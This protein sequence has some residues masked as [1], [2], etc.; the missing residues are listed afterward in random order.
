M[1]VCGTGLLFEMN[2]KIEK[3]EV[4]NYEQSLTYTIIFLLELFTLK[5][6]LLRPSKQ[7]KNISH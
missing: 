1:C 6:L 3:K 4:L 5:N 2:N 7:L